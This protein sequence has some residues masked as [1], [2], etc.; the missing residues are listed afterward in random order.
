MS[1]IF[2]PKTAILGVGRRILAVG[3]FFDQP[4]EL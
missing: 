3:S 4:K 1:A 2:D